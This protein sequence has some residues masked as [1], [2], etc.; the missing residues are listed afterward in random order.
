MKRK[1]GR[2][3]GRKEKKEGRTDED[4]QGWTKM[5]QGR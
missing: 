1:E 4:G 2:K 3:E 5:P